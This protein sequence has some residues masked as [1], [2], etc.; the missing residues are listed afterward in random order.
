MSGFVTGQSMSNSEVLSDSPGVTAV[1]AS[2]REFQL[3]VERSQAGE[4]R[5]GGF[6]E[7]V[8]APYVGARFVLAN[9]QYLR[10]FVLPVVVQTAISL[11]LILVLFFTGWFLAD[12][13]RAGITSVVNYFSADGV[14]EGVAQAANVLVYGLIFLVLFYLFQLIWRITGGIVNDYFGD[15]ITRQV[16][17]DLGIKTVQPATSMTRTVVSTARLI[18]ISHIVM[19][20]CSPLSVIPVVGTL[21]VLLVGTGAVLFLKGADELADPLMSLGLSRKEAF[22]LSRHYRWTAIG[23]AASRAGLEPVPFFG[24]LISSSE[25]V[26]RIAVAMRLL[27]RTESPVA[28]DP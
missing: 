11:S 25:S 17:Q 1:E 22:A 24:G 18:G 12:W 16:M 27:N 5:F 19:L 14:N 20:L 8:T 3:I 4:S 15:R 9:K 13:L 28:I 10:M 23:L 7:G 2:R 26:G 6:L 21:A